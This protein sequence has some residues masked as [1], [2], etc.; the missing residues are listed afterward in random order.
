MKSGFFALRPCAL[1]ALYTYEF[2]GKTVKGARAQGR[3]GHLLTKLYRWGLDG[4]LDFRNASPRR[5][6]SAGNRSRPGRGAQKDDGLHLGPHDGD[7]EAVV[8]FPYPRAQVRKSAA[9][10]S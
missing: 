5:I 4:H 1:G 10:T 9:D 7:G 3:S 8:R 6:T 2:P